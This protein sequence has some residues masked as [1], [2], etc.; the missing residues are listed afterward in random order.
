VRAEQDLPVR[1]RSQYPEQR[2][3]QKEEE[4][5]STKREEIARVHLYL[6]V[7]EVGVLEFRVAALAEHRVEVG[8]RMGLH[9]G[10]PLA[11]VPPHAL[12]AVVV[13]HEIGLQG[14]QHGGVDFGGETAP[15][16]HA[17]F[18]AALLGAVGHA[19]VQAGD[20]FGDHGVGHP[21]HGV[22]QRGHSEVVPELQREEVD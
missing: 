5:T 18:R 9:G 15:K 16:Y 4:N 14:S 3:W 1:A 20:V 19:G 22:E 10:D 6:G 11:E 12:A 7:L 13:R 2:H 17:R 8:L 21:V